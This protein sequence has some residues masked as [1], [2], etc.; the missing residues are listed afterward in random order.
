[1]NAKNLVVALSLLI[2]STV[3]AD[4]ATVIKLRNRVEKKSPEG[5]WTRLRFG[6]KLQERET[7]KTFKNSEVTFRIAKSDRVTIREKS[8]L[9][10]SQLKT[11]AQAT[12][13]EWGKFDFKIKTKDVKS[14]FIVTTPV[15]VGGVEGTVFRVT[16]EKQSGETQFFLL[17]GRLKVADRDGIMKTILM[18]DHFVKLNKS[19]TSLQPQPIPAN[20]KS[21]IQAQ[22]ESSVV[23]EQETQLKEA[24]VPAKDK[25]EQSS[26]YQEEP[27]TEEEAQN[28]LQ[29]SGQ[30][31]T[32]GFIS[33]E[34]GP[35]GEDI[36][37]VPQETKKKSKVIIQINSEE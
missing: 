32:G 2:C 13:A 30:N 17:T 29:Q 26:E 35:A 19:T 18:P 24:S 27:Q 5:S 28:R 1:M 37:I 8:C 21:E 11:R 33:Q 12:K 9:T 31:A 15:A 14:K 20:I 7:V 23:P 34:S 3:F 16:V 4:H 22:Q 6:N 10:F 36:F 25:E